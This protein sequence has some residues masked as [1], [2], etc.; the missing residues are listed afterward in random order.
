MK[1]HPAMEKILAIDLGNSNSVV[2]VFERSSFTSKF[3]KI[4][5]SG[6]ISSMLLQIPKISF[7]GIH[8]EMSIKSLGRVI[9]FYKE[10]T[11]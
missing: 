8:G 10:C 2:C 3:R 1:G 5:T 4:K 11:P 9:K 7:P 6:E